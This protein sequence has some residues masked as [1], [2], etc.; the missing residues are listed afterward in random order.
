VNSPTVTLPAW[1]S[2][3][4]VEPIDEDNPERCDLDKDLL[5]IVLDDEPDSDQA[6][7]LLAVLDYEFRRSMNGLPPRESGPGVSIH[8]NTLVVY[9][10]LQ[11]RRSKS[12]NVAAALR[13]ACA[14]IRQ[15]YDHGSPVRAD[16][17][18]LFPAYRGPLPRIQQFCLAAS[19]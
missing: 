9:A 8:G 15:M 4:L 5:V 13:D 3:G 1:R 7:Y 11:Q 14:G 10:P 6:L 19:R 2:R 16:G 18:Q 17:T 12:R